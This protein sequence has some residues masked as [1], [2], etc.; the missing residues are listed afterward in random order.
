MTNILI[1]TDDDRDSE[2][3]ELEEKLIFKNSKIKLLKKSHAE[4]IERIISINKNLEFLVKDQLH[5]ID[6]CQELMTPRQ[7]EKLSNIK[8]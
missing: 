2:I 5:L 7:L 3:A 1:D 8:F 4:E 6:K